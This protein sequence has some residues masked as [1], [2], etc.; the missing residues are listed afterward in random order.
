[1]PN[2]ETQPF[3]IR[4]ILSAIEKRKYMAIAIGLFVVS[5]FTWSGF[6]MPKIYEADST[7]SIEKDMVIKPLIQGVGVPVNDRL[8]N[9]KSEI[10]SQN[11]IEKVLNKLGV[12]VNKESAK[13]YGMIAG[14]QKNLTITVKGN[15]RETNLFNISYRGRDPKQVANLVNTIVGVYIDENLHSRRADTS[16]AYNF[17]QSQVLEY[18]SKLEESDRQIREFKEKNPNLIPQSESTLLARL[19]SQQTNKM[20]S[21][22]RLK[23]LLRKKEN[24]QKQLAGEKELTVAFVTREG[25][26]QA[27][28]SYLNNQL[29]LLMAKYTDNYP[30]VIKIKS[31]IEELK[32]Q[33]ARAKASRIEGSGSETAAMNPVY[34]QLKEDLAKTDAEI[35]SLRA[36]TSE[37]SRQQQQ[38]QKVFGR[39]PKEQEEWT[40]LQRDRNVFQ[41]IY[42][43]LLQKLENAKVSKELEFSDKGEGFK[44]VD[45]ATVPLYPIE[46]NR[47]K[48]ILLGILLGIASGV[49][50]VLGL[51]YLDH[52]FK[53]EESIEDT[54]KLPVLAA[55]PRI[56]TEADEASAKKLEFKVFAVS[57]AYLLVICL[58]LIT[59]LLSRYLGLKIF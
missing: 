56:V 14:I 2:D 12:V 57:G 58:V 53:N 19:E 49:G 10:T 27:R 48:M 22:L 52:S 36:R 37:L 29:M 6:L 24:L 33:I 25:S 23:E 13:Y 51:D 50:A 38:V 26:P 35:E 55:I 16:D 17:I 4:R 3:D 30:E 20:E 32:K 59:E 47:I 46:P 54:L 11:I 18:K 28:L 40:K 15:E 39:M 43:Q 1:M 7:V 21:D 31:E 41:Q 34:Q 45:Y 42:D 5:A 8:V 9:L 44:I